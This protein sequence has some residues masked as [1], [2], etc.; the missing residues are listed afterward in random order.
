VKKD[1]LLILPSVLLVLIFL[2]FLS[3]SKIATKDGLTQP[4]A[5]SCFDK[6]ANG[7][8]DK[9]QNIA[10]FEGQNLAIPKEVYAA[11]APLAVLGAVSDQKWIEVDL[12]EQKLKAWEG[13]KLFLETLVSTGLPGTPTPQ[14][15]FRIWIKLRAVRMEGGSGRG[16][17][18]LPNVPYTMFFENSEVPG[19]RGYGLHGTYWHNDFGR[20]KSHGCVNLPTPIA[21]QLYEWTTPVLPEGKG[22]VR[23]DANNVGTRILIHE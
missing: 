5:D 1:F 10:T 7:E 8:L 9:D 4:C 2:G 17:Y 16:Y 15:E 22:M 23:A 12:S 11:P 18:N 3:N 14:G 13:N 6:T 21:K 19:W 20:Q